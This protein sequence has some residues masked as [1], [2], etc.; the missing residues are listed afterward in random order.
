MSINKAQEPP[1]L[2]MYMD[3]TSSFSAEP[4]Q[5]RM[6]RSVFFARHNRKV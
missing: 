5:F 2:D 4:R 6:K 1:S 3:I